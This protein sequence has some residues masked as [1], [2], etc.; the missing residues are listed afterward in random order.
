MENIVNNQGNKTKYVFIEVL[1]IIACFLVIVNHTN[2]EIFLYSAPS[3]KWNLSLTYFFISKMAVPIFVMISG[4]TMLGKQDDY[5]K[6]MKRVI[7]MVITLVLFSVVVYTYQCMNGGYAVFSIVECLKMMIQYPLTVAYW[8]LYMYIGLLIMM[9][10]LQKLVS[11]L[12]KRDC[13][14]FIV[15]SLVVNGICPILEHVWPNVAYTRLVDLAVFDS[16]I[17]M[18]MLGHYMKKYVTF[19]KK[20]VAAA[21]VVFVISLLFNVIMT[22]REYALYGPA[23]FLFFDN[24]AFLPIMLEAISFFYIV[25]NIPWGE[26]LGKVIKVVGGCTF[27]IYLLSDIFID[28]FHAVY[29]GLCDRGMY[30]IFAV[31]LFE[32]FVFMLGFVVTYVLKKIPLIK[33]LL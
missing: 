6:S 25:M 26:K 23:N 12:S 29:V 17:A 21:V 2:S 9:P 13:E 19:S 27:G 18:L 22:K 33:K 30:P 4:Y 16:Y 14:I 20:K 15:I 31:I 32:V 5:K 10:F 11:L 28:K 3:L 1:R 24:I 8:Y 7:R